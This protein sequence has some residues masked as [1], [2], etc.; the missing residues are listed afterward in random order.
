MPNRTFR[1]QYLKLSLI[2][3]ACCALLMAVGYFPTMRLAGAAG[4]S[5]M[6]AGIGASLT[7]ALLGAI[8][9]AMAIGRTPDKVPMAILGATTIRFLVILPLAACLAF[10]G[11]FQQTPL[12]VWIAFSYLILLAVDTLAALWVFKPARRAVQ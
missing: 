3:G 4:I 9:I 11:L 5:A 1:H 10:C 8:P 12:I 7:A 2:S 6:A